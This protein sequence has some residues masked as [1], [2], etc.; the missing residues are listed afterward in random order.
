MVK[1]L[2][3]ISAR[4]VCCKARPGLPTIY[5]TQDLNIVVEAEQSVHGEALQMQPTELFGFNTGE[6]RDVDLNA[7]SGQP[8]LYFFVFAQT[9]QKSSCNGSVWVNSVIAM[10]SFVVLC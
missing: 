5:I 3:F 1:L 7:T 9:K 4:L 10:M 6:W 8:F 2:P